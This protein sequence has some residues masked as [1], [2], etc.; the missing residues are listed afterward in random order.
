MRILIPL[1]ALVG[2]P[3]KAPPASEPAAPA[4]T[5]VV[6]PEGAEP[7]P[8]VPVVP[9][10]AECVEECM[11]ASMA[12]ARSPDAIRADCEASCGAGEATPVSTGAELALMGGKRVK[13]VGLLKRGD[14]PTGGNGAYVELGDGSKLWVDSDGVPEGWERFVDVRISVVGTLGQGPTSNGQRIR[15]PFLEAMEE[16]LRSGEMLGDA[17]L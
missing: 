11:H 8:A 5:P 15:I 4:R 10:N 13:A 7:E 1:F 16:P 6:E 2:C 17:P 3:S 14:Y 12:E 9:V